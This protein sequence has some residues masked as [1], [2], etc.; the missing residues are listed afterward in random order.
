ME[1]GTTSALSHRMS[2]PSTSYSIVRRNGFST[3]CVVLVVVV[4][5]ITT[6]FNGHKNLPRLLSIRDATSRKKDFFN[7]MFKL[8]R[9]MEISSTTIESSSSNINSPPNNNSVSCIIYDRPPRTGS[10]TVY[11]RLDVCLS[12]RGYGSSLQYYH[13]TRNHLL[14]DRL[15]SKNSTRKSLTS[16]HFRSF[17]EK[18]V[19]K[20][21]SHCERIL[22]LTSTRPMRNRLLSK[23]KYHTPLSD[24]NIVS[25]SSIVPIQNFEKVLN[26]QIGQ[27]SSELRDAEKEYENYPGPGS[28]LIYPDFVI[29]SHM[30]ESDFESM[31]NAL[32]CSAEF[33]SANVHMVETMD[34]KDH[35]RLLAIIPVTMGDKRHKYLLNIASDNSKGLRKAALF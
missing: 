33:K 3:Y 28:S 15:I 23:L 5:V 29:R 17:S 10:T 1:P 22:Y 4:F 8:K 21:F 2:K 12:Q 19:L 27:N 30:F 34:D 31:L 7:P 18:S 25:E 26:E 14:I 6:R 35:E 20:L 11:K 9:N 13:G 16:R 32:N 24:S